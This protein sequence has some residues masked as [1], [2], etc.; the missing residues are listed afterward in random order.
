MIRGNQ[1]TSGT[2][3]MVSKVCLPPL[4]IGD[5]CG[6]VRGTNDEVE[7]VGGSSGMVEGFTKMLTSCLIS[8][9]VGP[10]MRI[11]RSSP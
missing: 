10:C 1:E 3:R 9:G 6:E 5:Q 11:R 8:R 2:Q 4:V 7:G